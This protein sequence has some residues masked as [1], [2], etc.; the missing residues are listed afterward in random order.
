MDLATALLGSGERGETRHV[1]LGALLRAQQRIAT[2]DAEMV[3]HAMVAPWRRAE[4]LV[5]VAAAL[6]E[7]GRIAEVRSILRARAGVDPLPD[8]HVA[9]GD[10]DARAKRWAAVARRHGAPELRT[11]VGAIAGARRGGDWLGLAMRSNAALA[12]CSSGSWEAS[13]FETPTALSVVSAAP[14]SVDAGD[15][16]LALPY[17]LRRAG[18]T[19]SL[20]PSLTGLPRLLGS[21][22]DPLERLR[23]WAE[24]LAAQADAARGRAR[25]L[26]R[27]GALVEARLMSVRRPAALRRLVAVALSRWTIWPAQLARLTRVDLSTAWRAVGQAAELGLVEAVPTTR[28]SRGDATTYA[29]PPWLQLAGL[30][31]VRR[32]R[33]ASVGA[34]EGRGA[35]LA[36]ALAEM[37]AVLAETSHL[38]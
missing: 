13:V 23:L 38:A 37:D 16:A 1:A 14:G 21:E 18:L 2:L 20:I 25:T 32:G 30:I 17:A 33:P 6:H 19:R 15:L 4:T 8:E 28:R 29:A 3:D 31:A 34:A 7:T 9:M 26:E 5:G 36:A 22:A 35:E 27:Y 11:L 12:R 24:G 10:I